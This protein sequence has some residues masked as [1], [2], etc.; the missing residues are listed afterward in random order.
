M[1]CLI[2]KPL[3]P[4]QREGKI[5]FGSPCLWLCPTMVQVKDLAQPE[6]RVLRAISPALGRSPPLSYPLEGQP[7]PEKP[8]GS[9]YLK[10]HCFPI[11]S[12]LFI[13]FPHLESTPSS[14]SEVSQF[15]PSFRHLLCAVSPPEAASSANCWSWTEVRKVSQFLFSDS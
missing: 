7:A 1:R 8:F 5:P 6:A 15:Y 2:G 3:S 9:S 12:L 11:F 14:Q 13:F 4:C 10:T